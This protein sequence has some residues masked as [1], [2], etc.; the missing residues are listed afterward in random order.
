MLNQIQIMGRV[1]KDPE[2]KVTSGGVSVTRFSLAV[3]RD[4]KGRDGARE[5]D[6]FDCIAWRNTADFVAKYL[7]KGRMAIVAGSMQSRKWKDR[8]GNNRISWEIQVENVY[9]GDS[10]RDEAQRVP[11]EDRYSGGQSQQR[12]SAYVELGDDEGLPF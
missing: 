6:F 3:D 7:E 2:H 9:F 4:F 12:D 10:R 5:A 11:S 1:V 8:D